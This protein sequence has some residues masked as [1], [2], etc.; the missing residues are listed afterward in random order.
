MTNKSPMVQGLKLKELKVNLLNGSTDAVILLP[1]LFRSSGEC[2]SI[3][4]E[5]ERAAR[6]YL[7]TRN[8][9]SGT[10][11]GRVAAFLER[12]SSGYVAVRLSFVRI[13]REFSCEADFHGF[14]GQLGD[15]IRE[16]AQSEFKRIC[17][18]KTRHDMPS[19]GIGI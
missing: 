8:G 19:Q 12:S 16:T 17:S 6:A 13:R 7:R 10:R 3:A 15:A 14:I 4:P 11:I 5:T 18:V 1:K 9:A 2:Y